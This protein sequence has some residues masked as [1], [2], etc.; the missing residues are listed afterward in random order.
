MA[1][2]RKAMKQAARQIRRQESGV[3]L[4]VGQAPKEYAKLT[5]SQLL[6]GRVAMRA[7]INAVLSLPQEEV[8]TRARQVLVEGLKQSR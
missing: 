6:Q 3:T 4:P 7:A 5:R 1:D 8:S 2:R